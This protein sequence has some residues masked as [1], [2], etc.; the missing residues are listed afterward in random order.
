M[1]QE[2]SSGM[3]TMLY[4]MGMAPWMYWLKWFIHCMIPQQISIAFLLLVIFHDI[5]CSKNSLLENSNGFLI[6]C[7][8]LSYSFTLTTTCFL[9]VISFSHMM[10]QKHYI[11]IAILTMFFWFV[12]PLVLFF[13]SYNNPYTNQILKY[14]ILLFP[15]VCIFLGI[16]V[17]A[18]Y[19]QMGG[20]KWSQ[21]F[22]GVS[23]LTTYPSIGTLMVMLIIDSVIY[24]CIAWYLSEVIPSEHRVHKAWNFLYFKSFWKSQNYVKP[25]KE[26]VQIIEKS[27]VMEAPSKSM[28]PVIQ[29]RNLN[30]AFG[31]A[32]QI[33]TD[34]SLDIYENQ[35]TVILSRE[36]DAKS[37][38]LNIIAGKIYFLLFVIRFSD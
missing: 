3:N 18:Q 23:T 1:A 35:L 15:N 22:T 24:F 27:A 2:I 34:L 17:I 8:L 12:H 20:I 30:K 36:K 31:E 5:P 11:I 7:T 6:F 21:F 33:I 38:I 32:R 29:I 26:E 25:P 14:L 37:T 4:G 28:V 16:F 13:V 19:E 9:C 10:N